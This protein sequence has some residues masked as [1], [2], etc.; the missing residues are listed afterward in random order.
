MAS[1]MRD[2]EEKLG[3]FISIILDNSNN[4]RQIL[5]IVKF[6][7]SLRSWAL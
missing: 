6:G 5:C 4:V 3:H 7:I 2:N 1:L